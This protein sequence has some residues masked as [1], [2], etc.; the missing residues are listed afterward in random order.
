MKLM[1]MKRTPSSKVAHPKR[2]KNPVSRDWL[3]SDNIDS[4]VNCTCDRCCGTMCL[5]GDEYESDSR[6]A[7]CAD[8]IFHLEKQ[9]LEMKEQ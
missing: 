6:R 2:K 5:L 1:R 7:E 9:F 3:C 4:V 8:D